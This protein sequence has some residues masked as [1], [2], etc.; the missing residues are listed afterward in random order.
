MTPANTIPL[1]DARGA[2]PVHE[3]NRIKNDANAIET[4]RIMHGDVQQAELAP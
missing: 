1:A 3:L 2:P 4:E